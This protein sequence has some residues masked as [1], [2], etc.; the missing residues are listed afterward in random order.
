[1]PEEAPQYGD[2]SEQA[3]QRKLLE[4]AGTGRRTDAPQPPTAQPPGPAPQPQP[5][6][7]VQPSPR[8][9]LTPNDMRP[10]GP[11]FMQPKLAPPPSWRQQLRDWGQHPEANQIR[12][13]SEKADAQLPKQP[14][15]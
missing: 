8:Q 9:P 4:S 11:V 10:G 7:P 12:R 1:M 3:R 14:E 13:L 6:G 5:G 15:Q 2:G